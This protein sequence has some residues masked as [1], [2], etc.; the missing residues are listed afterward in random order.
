MGGRFEQELC[1]WGVW[2]GKFF[3]EGGRMSLMFSSP[4]SSGL[5]ANCCVYILFHVFPSA[6]QKGLV[7]AL[8][9]KET[10]DLG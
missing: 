8:N 7:L 6:F 3:F 5:E 2:S 4:L 1:G 10:R 9:I